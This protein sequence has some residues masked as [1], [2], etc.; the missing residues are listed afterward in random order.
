M[1]WNRARRQDKNHII[2]YLRYLPIWQKKN[3]SSK[4]VPIYKSRGGK[5]KKFI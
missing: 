1:K 2:P 4:C 3:L 5:A